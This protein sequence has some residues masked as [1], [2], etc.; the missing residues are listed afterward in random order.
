[1]KADGMGAMDAQELERIEP[2]QKAG[3]RFLVQIGTLRPQPHVVV[4]GFE[5]DDGRDLDDC[6]AIDGLDRDPAEG[7]R[8]A[9]HN[10]HRRL[11]WIPRVL[12]FLQ[13]FDWVTLG[14]RPHSA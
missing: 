6:D 3:Q 14:S 11:G 2:R 13:T 4:F 1:M 8:V 7:I 10:G 12:R 5:A 9:G